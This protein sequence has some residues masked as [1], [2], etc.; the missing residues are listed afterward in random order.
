M[1]IAHFD[2]ISIEMF[3]PENDHHRST[4]TVLVETSVE[5]EK[6]CPCDFHSIIFTVDIQAKEKHIRSGWR[7]GNFLRPRYKSP[8]QLN[9]AT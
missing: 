7:N 3:A 8:F 2:H 9:Y 4:T 6:E 5:S 1:F